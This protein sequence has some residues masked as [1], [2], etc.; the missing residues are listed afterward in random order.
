MKPLVGFQS[1]WRSP[2]CIAAR[3]TDQQTPTPTWEQTIPSSEGPPLPRAMNS[4]ASDSTVYQAGYYPGRPNPPPPVIMGTNG[5]WWLPT[6]THSWT[7][8][9]DPE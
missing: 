2:L 1:H 5:P 7:P 3:D 6:S 8:E 9:Q 4:T